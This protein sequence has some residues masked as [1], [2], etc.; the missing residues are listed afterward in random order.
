[1][2]SFF[3]NSLIDSIKKMILKNIFMI[4]IIMSIKI[5]NIKIVPENNLIVNDKYFIIDNNK[6]CYGQYKTNYIGKENRFIFKNVIFINNKYSHTTNILSTTD[7]FLDKIVKLDLGLPT[8]IQ[9]LIE[10]FY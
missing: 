4:Y 10:E 2:T 7:Q 5:I 9:R 1:M 8:D 3:P 6:L